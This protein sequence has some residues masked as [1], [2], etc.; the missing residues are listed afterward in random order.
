MNKNQAIEVE[1]LL[2]AH[3]AGLYFVKV[4]PIVKPD[5]TPD[6]KPDDKP[7]ETVYLAELKNSPQADSSDETVLKIFE[8]TG[9]S[10]TRAKKIFYPIT[11]L[12][13]KQS[14]QWQIW[15]MQFGDNWVNRYNASEKL[16]NDY[17]IILKDKDDVVR[18]LNCR[19]FLARLHALKICMTGETFI[20]ST[21]TKDS[22]NTDKPTDKPI[23]IEY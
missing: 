9:E 2:K 14:Q 22:S 12:E 5:D 19:A 13:V 3:K 21:I 15:L 11:G 6:D 7:I 1:K 17:Y 10:A 8:G 18:C 4:A 20:L 16:E 23:E